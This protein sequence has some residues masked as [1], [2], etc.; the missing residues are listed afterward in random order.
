MTA[1]HRL[2][3]AFPRFAHML[4]KPAPRRRMTINAPSIVPDL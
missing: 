2:I 3:R 1:R 4:V